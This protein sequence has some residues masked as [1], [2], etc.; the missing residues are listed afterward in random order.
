M[1]KVSLA[2][3]L[4]LSQEVIASL[5]D[6]QLQEIEGGAAGLEISCIGGSNS[7]S[8]TKLEEASPEA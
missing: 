3:Q 1:K 5:S 4:E 2:D 7:C 6:E 8:K